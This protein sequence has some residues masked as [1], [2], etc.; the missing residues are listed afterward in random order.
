MRRLTIIVTALFL[1]LS[2]YAASLD[3]TLIRASNEGKET[4]ARLKDLEPKLKKVFG[5]QYYQQ[6]G[7]QTESLRDNDRKLL[8]LGEGFTIFVTSKAVE[9]KR[10]TLELEWYSGK[11][12]LV[13]STAKLSEKEPLLIKGPAVG[14]DWIVLA[15][16][17]QP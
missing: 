12:L 17:M 3:A 6:L 4:D 16:T 5:F 1:A 15:L 8:N 14:R 11:T 2:A 13:K 7:H 10:H 9:K